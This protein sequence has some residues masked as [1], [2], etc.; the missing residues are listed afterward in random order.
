[1][2]PDIEDILKLKKLY[3][4]QD[5]LKNLQEKEFMQKRNQM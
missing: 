1:M 5:Y 3:Q 2:L 4:K